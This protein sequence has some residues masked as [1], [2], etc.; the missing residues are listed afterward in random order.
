MTIK[1]Y[2]SPKSSFLSIEKDTAIIIE[3]LINND[4]LKK[5]LYYS[6]PNA[7]RISRKLTPQE[8][9]EI[10]SKYIKIVP[11]IKIDTSIQT[12]LV[13][14]FDQF[15]PSGNPEFRDNNIIIDIICHYDVWQLEDFQ[16]R[17]YKIAG[18][19]DFLLNDQR[20]T[21]IGKL[22]FLT[23]NQVNIHEDYGILSLVYSA[24]HGEEDKKF[25][26][27]P[28]DEAIFQQDFKEAY[29]K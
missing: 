24:T 17:P 7:L 12:Y 18:E 29:N 26:L 27:N 28:I 15:I 11:K 23:A 6:E 8:E 2:I 19:I 13:I 10:I 1:D 3:K 20:L 4:R 9:Q 22:E 16:L 5:L 14:S 21:G 25:N